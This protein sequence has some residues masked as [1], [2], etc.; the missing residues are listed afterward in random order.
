MNNNYYDVLSRK[1][2]RAHPRFAQAGYSI[3]DLIITSAVAGVLSLGAVGMNGLVQDARMT[4]VVNQIMGDLNLARNEA[5][6]RNTPITLCKSSDGASCSDEAAWRDGWIVFTDH[7]K[8][9]EVDANEAIIRVQQA[10]TG[11]MTLRYGNTGTYTYVRYNSSGEAS[12]AATFTFCDGR[13]ADKAK[14]VIVYW[15]GR[16][17]ISTRTSEDE[18][19]TCT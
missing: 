16:P 8:N 2:W 18:S 3:F 19:L 4:T 9:R 15:T 14:A 5:I 13:G 10:L 12:R 1:S 17:R 7:N 6:K 11:N